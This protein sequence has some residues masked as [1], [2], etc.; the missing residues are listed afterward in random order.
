MQCVLFPDHTHFLFDRKLCHNDT[1][2][3]CLLRKLLSETDFTFL[4][5]CSFNSVIVVLILSFIFFYIFF[6]LKWFLTGNGIIVIRQL[7]TCYGN[8]SCSF[9]P[10]ILKLCSCF[11]HVLYVYVIV[12]P[13]VVRLYVEIIHDP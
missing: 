13:W 3:F 10:I 8:S 9:S 6:Q 5:A 4:H 11:C 7:V 12:I 2:A 1:T